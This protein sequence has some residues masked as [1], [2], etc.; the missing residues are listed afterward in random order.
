M[1]AVVV[2]LNDGRVTNAR[3]GLVFTCEQMATAGLVRFDRAHLERDL[4]T[5]RIARGQIDASLLGLADQGSDDIAGHEVSRHRILR[6]V[7][8]HFV[9]RRLDLRRGGCVFAA[10]GELRVSSRDAALDT[11]QGEPH[12]RAESLGCQQALWQIVHGAELQRAYCGELVAFFC[13]R[14]NRG[15]IRACAERTQQVDAFRARIF[16]MLAEGRGQQ[17]EVALV[18]G[19]GFARDVELIRAHDAH[20]GVRVDHAEVVA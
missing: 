6:C 3:Y 14:Q 13:E 4:A 19:E 20:G 10:L 9:G 16:R 2:Q 5:E 15:K 8:H 17:H 18:I 12:G 11:T 7:G 1:N